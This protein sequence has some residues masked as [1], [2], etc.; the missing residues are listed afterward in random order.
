MP[1]VSV[2]SIGSGHAGT[3]DTLAYMRALVRREYGLPIV[4]DTAA[5][6]VRGTGVNSEA[7]AALIRRFLVDHISFLRDPR[8]IEL[9]TA[10]ATQLTTIRSMGSAS[11]DCDDVA[12]L[13]AALGLAIGLRA[14]FVVVGRSQFEH[15]FTVLG[16]P[17]GRSWWELDTTRPFQTIPAEL[18]R[19]VFTVEV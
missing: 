16:D 8:G 3:R 18:Q 9:L 6:I 4:R 11:G 15:V 5:A 12:V 10:P 19:N 1:P 13:G 17:A 7:Q 14:R 2:Y